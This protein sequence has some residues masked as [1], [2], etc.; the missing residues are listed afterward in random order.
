MIYAKLASSKCNDFKSR[1]D[2]DDIIEG[3]GLL[4][5]LPVS[6]QSAGLLPNP[7]GNQYLITDFISQ[8]TS[9]HGNI[10]KI[11]VTLTSFM[12]CS[13]YQK[14]VTIL[15]CT[16]YCLHN[17]TYHFLQKMKLEDQ[18]L[19]W[20]LF[21]RLKWL[22]MLRIFSAIQRTKCQTSEQYDALDSMFWHTSQ[23]L[24]VDDFNWI[25]DLKKSRCS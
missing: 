4:S 11:M 19:F 24:I 20:R 18:I 25:Y 10:D 12:N 5:I 2:G 17:L 22:E 21:W 16:L 9:T 23:I 1:E 14:F 3:S 6:A 8:I 15:P 13:F 7:R